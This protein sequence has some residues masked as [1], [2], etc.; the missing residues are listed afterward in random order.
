MNASGELQ[1]TFSFQEP[2]TTASIQA[3]VLSQARGDAAGDA[4]SA[5][6]SLDK[7]ADPFLDRGGEPLQGKGG[8]PNI[9]LVKVCVLLKTES[10]VPRLEFLAALKE[11]DDL[12]VLGVSGHPV[13][14][15][16]S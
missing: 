9:A 2:G 13:P 15:F 16:R 12:A 4:L 6:R 3:L 10:G 7:L 8:W 14:G 5:R 1:P 11:A